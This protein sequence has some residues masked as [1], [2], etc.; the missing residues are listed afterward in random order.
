MKITLFFVVIT[1]L[2]IV[3]LMSKS[4]NIDEVKD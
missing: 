2:I 1:I 3:I 4:K